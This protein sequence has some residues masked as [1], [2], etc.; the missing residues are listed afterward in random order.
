MQKRAI[1]TRQE[2]LTAAINCF[3]R[4][5][6]EATG[7][8]EICSE[9]GLSKGAFYHHFPSKHAVFMAL[10]ENWLEGLDHQLKV[11]SSGSKDVPSGLVAMTDVLPGV[12][13]DAGDQVR[14][15][16]EF[17]TQATR[18]E[19]IF[20]TLIKPY[21]RY[22]KYFANLIEEGVDEGSLQNVQPEIVS[23]VIISLALGVLLQG[24]LDQ[25]G[26]DWKAVAEMGMKMIAANIQ[27]EQR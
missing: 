26:T 24:L 17:W 9:A 1:E 8:A 7:V 4:E 21:K 27:K 18:D 2:I 5:G 3:S 22:T 16:L 10:L 25:N 13:S 20:Q 15:Y 19:A 12:F 23:R 11:I 14:L 6:Y